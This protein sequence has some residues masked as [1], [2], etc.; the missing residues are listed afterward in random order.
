MI[1]LDEPATK[2]DVIV[3]CASI[4]MLVIG[5]NYAAAFWGKVGKFEKIYEQLGAELPLATK[6]VIAFGDVGV[7][8]GFLIFALLPALTA[9]F[10]RNNLIKVIVA[11]VCVAGMFILHWLILS[12]LMDPMIRL[13][14]TMI[15]R[16]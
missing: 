11:A 4:P 9:L 2:A 8:A 6:T 14:Q 5:L 10:V 12:G 13:Q 1:K 15:R 16:S 3:W 7:F